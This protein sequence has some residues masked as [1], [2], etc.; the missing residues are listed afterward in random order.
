MSRPGEEELLAAA[1][2][3]RWSALLLRGDLG[4]LCLAVVDTNGDGA[5]VATVRFHLD[6]DDVWREQAW[7]N[8]SVLE[9]GWVSGVAYAYGRGPAGWWMHLAETAEGEPPGHLHGTLSW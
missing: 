2:S 4:R 7:E 9:D 8:A 1:G 5:F 3:A 6:D